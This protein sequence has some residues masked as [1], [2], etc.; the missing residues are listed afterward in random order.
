MRR[1]RCCAPVDY[2]VAVEMVAG[3]QEL[4][5]ASISDIVAPCHFKKLAC[6]DSLDR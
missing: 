5:A 2:G 6:L 4:V 1:R 3:R